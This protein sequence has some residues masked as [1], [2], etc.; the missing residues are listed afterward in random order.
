M[1][2]LYSSFLIVLSL[3]FSAC[4][5]YGSVTLKYP[6]APVVIVPTDIKS[7][8]MV[9]RCLQPK[10]A[11]AKHNAITEAIITG[12]VAGSDKLASDECLKAVF[13]RLN[14]F[15]DLTVTYAPITHL[16]G[17]G[18]RTTPPPLD[19]KRVREICDSSKS[20]VLLV[21]E[22]FD[23]NSDVVMAS[24]TT[25]VTNVLTGNTT[26]PAP[27]VIHLNVLGY[28][29]MYDPRTEKIVDQFESSQ[30]MTFA[31]Q[32]PLNLPPP[33]ALGRTAYS[34]GDIYS[35]RFLPGYYY[36]RREMYKRGKGHYKQQ[37]RTAFRRSE[38]ADWKG[39][40]E[41]WGQI[42]NNAKGR[43]AGRACL[44]M[45][46]AREVLGNTQDALDWAKK[47]YEDFGNK[48]CRDYA[49]ILRRRLNEGW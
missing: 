39:A 33:E 2:R 13:D 25:A 14:G 8:A 15:H 46:V 18:G 1:K 47:G 40:E 16:V 4:S 28:W 22:M 23:S 26:P 49:N 31:P 43:N 48:L 19:W 6:T 37:F 7:I 45:A 9:N 35:G 38:V 41:I 11:D 34:M 32:G 5:K 44:N 30:T 24:V 21:L 42:G 12:E 36:V 10:D 17:S 20:D 29:R 3:C 27:P